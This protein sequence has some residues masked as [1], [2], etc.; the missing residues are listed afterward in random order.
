MFHEGRMSSCGKGSNVNR[1]HQANILRIQWEP[2]NVSPNIGGKISASFEEE[3]EVQGVWKYV[4]KH[5]RNNVCERKPNRLS[6]Q[7]SNASRGG[8]RLEAISQGVEWLL[9]RMPEA[10]RSRSDSN[11]RAGAN[12]N[13]MDCLRHSPARQFRCARDESMWN[14][15]VCKS[16]VVKFNLATIF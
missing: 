8:D 11:T 12:Q 10:M 1:T 16:A 7:I 13:F 3:C 5:S 6:I 15:C 9:E 4:Q 2:L 14:Q